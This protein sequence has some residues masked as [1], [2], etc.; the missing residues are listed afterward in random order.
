MTAVYQY[1]S[2]HPNSPASVGTQ[3]MVSRRG[4][5]CDVLV[6]EDRM[7]G[8]LPQVPIMSLGSGV[9]DD[10][11]WVPRPC[12]VA[13]GSDGLLLEGGSPLDLSGCTFPQ[14]L[15][16]DRVIV[17]F[18]GGDRRRPLI[19]GSLKHPRSL[20]PEENSDSHK[21]RRI[22]RGNRVQ[23]DDNGRVYVDI[24]GQT[25]G[26]VDQEDGSEEEVGNPQMTIISPSATI[27]I[28]G[29]EIN[30]ALEEGK[31]MKVDG[32]GDGSTSLLVGG[33]QSGSVQQPVVLKTA[34]NNITAV[35]TEWLPLVQ[36]AAGLFGI[37][38]PESA[39]NVA[40]LNTGS[41]SG[42]MSYASRS[43]ETD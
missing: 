37:P 28:D 10:N 32:A 18:V 25:T 29:D 33:T 3:N 17:A 4:I 6:V 22:I 21:Y 23:V 34:L 26:S 16:G 36:A 31:T 42:G 7:R 12:T 2:P 27:M 9:S 15:D 1:N 30:V 40:L 11:S 41:D 24:T 13:I 14:D 35:L 5:F 19:L 43:L 20:Y 39:T 8:L 38:L